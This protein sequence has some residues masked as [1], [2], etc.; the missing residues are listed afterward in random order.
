MAVSIGV[1]IRTIEGL[2]G[3]KDVSEWEDNF[4][5]SI[6]RQSRHGTHTT[7]LTEKQIEIIE[8]IHNKHFGD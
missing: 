6:L 2:V 1:M 8:R 5:Q 3:T 7:S 4:I